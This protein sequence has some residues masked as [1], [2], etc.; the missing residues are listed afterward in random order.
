MADVGEP[1]LSAERPDLG[2]IFE[3]MARL[4]PKGS[5]GRKLAEYALGLEARLGRAAAELEEAR[6]QVVDW[7]LAAS[8]YLS[9]ADWAHLPD[10][11][12][13]DAQSE[14][15]R[16]AALVEQEKEQQCAF[17][18]CTNPTPCPEH[19]AAVLAEQE[20][21]QRCDFGSCVYP[22]GH[23]GGHR[24]ESEAYTP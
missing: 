5:I 21:E 10:D 8:H 1:R 6:F 24:F 4:W 2:A 14:L 15:R 23:K 20:K 9:E 19:E 17:Y 12:L 11:Q 18:G 7:E 3:D 22:K 16:L 13:S